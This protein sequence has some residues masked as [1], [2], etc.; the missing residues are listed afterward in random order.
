MNKPMKLFIRLVTA[1]YRGALLSMVLSCVTHCQA[2]YLNVIPDCCT[3]AI[4]LSKQNGELQ[5]Q[6]TNT[7]TVLDSTRAASKRVVVATDGRLADLEKLADQSLR[8]Q[9]GLREQAEER[10]AVLLLENAKWVPKTK[11]GRFWRGKVMPAL[12]I[13]GGITLTVFT[14]KSLP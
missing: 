7:R 10:N 2:Q 4:S 8:A 5:Q 3:Q 14:Y 12:A 6:L 1:L 11:F 9:T 13:V